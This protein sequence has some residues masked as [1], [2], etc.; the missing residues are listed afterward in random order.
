MNVGK[1]EGIELRPK[2]VA[3]RAESGVSQLLLFASASAFDD[4]V[5]RKFGILGSLREAAGEVIETAG[6]PGIMQAKAV[7]AKGDELF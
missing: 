4:V 5:Q 6:E 2:N 1:I 3:L 7:H